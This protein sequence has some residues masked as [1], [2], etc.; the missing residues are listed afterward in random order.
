MVYLVIAFAGVW[1]YL[2]VA[3]LVFGWSLVSPLVQLPVAF[4]PAIGAVVVRRWVT[5]EGFADAGLRPRFRASW[6]QWLA[7]WFGPL[8]ITA[9][10][11]ACA[12]AFGWW[13]ADLSPVDGPAGIAVL[14]V[15]QFVLTPVYAG[16]ELGWTSFLWPRLIPG[17]PL[18][19]MM[20]TGLIWA[21][22]HFPLAFL[23]Y[24]VYDDH[25]ISMLLWTLMFML[26]EVLLC[27]LYKR[28][29]SVWITSLAH[30]GNN[31][32]TGV[33]TEQLL[34]DGGKLTALQ[35]LVCTDVA[36]AVVCLPLLRTAV[37]RRDKRGVDAKASVSI[38]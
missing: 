38:S 19:S 27:W 33:L 20:L 28:S 6:R 35:V 21:V 14:L 31:L 12:A 8:G 1:P 24:V 4:M 9:L 5:R 17:R 16:E 11:L 26:Y 18:P 29:G 32:I 13:H 25:T 15:V 37:F 34:T 23:G 30:A 2:F 22:W 10:I 36:L 7:A 3:R